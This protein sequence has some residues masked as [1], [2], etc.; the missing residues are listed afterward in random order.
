MWLQGFID[1]D[2]S[3]CTTL[4]LTKLLNIFSVLTSSLTFLLCQVMFLVLSDTLV[5]LRF[6]VDIHGFLVLYPKDFGDTLTF[7]LVPQ[8]IL[9]CNGVV[10]I[11]DGIPW[12]V[13]HTF[14]PLFSSE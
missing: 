13:V 8:A 4:V 11:L 1:I 14:I 6:Y 5:G 10:F 9:F 12:N 3:W 7:V 2:V